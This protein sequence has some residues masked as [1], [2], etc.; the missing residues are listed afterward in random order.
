MCC[1]AFCYQSYNTYDITEALWNK[2]G[3]DSAILFNKFKKAFTKTHAENHYNFVS[4]LLLNLI[5]QPCE[6]EI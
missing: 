3:N 5:E 6:R 4:W 1:I 2:I